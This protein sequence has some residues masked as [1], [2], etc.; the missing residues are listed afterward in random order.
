[1]SSKVELQMGTPL[2]WT[3][4]RSLNCWIVELEHALSN[5]ECISLYR[6]PFSTVRNLAHP[7]EFLLPRYA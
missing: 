4:S 7:G 2:F 3:S 5:L 6:S 1:M